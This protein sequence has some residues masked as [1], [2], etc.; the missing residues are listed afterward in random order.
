M[1]VMIRFFITVCLVFAALPVQGQDI[2]PGAP[3]DSPQETKAPEEA[4]PQTSQPQPAGSE[5][6]EEI[7]TLGPGNIT[8]NFKGADIKTVLSY[9][10]EVSG[11]DIVPSQDVKGPVDVKL[12]NKPWKVALDIIVRN[13][14]FAYER[15]GDIIRVDTVDKLRQQEVVTETYSL[16]Y[17]VAKDIT[18][19]IKD[20]LS[21][22]GKIMYDERTN[23]LLVTDIPTN[24]Y[25]ISQVVDRLDSK[26][27]QVLIEAKIIETVLG[28][29]EKMGIDW[30]IKMAASGAKRP[31]TLPFEN[32]KAPFGSKKDAMK[33]FFPMVQI[34]NPQTATGVGSISTTT[35]ASEFPSD[36]GGPVGFPFAEKDIFTF[37]T[38]D[39]SQFSAVLEMLK[40][41]ADTQVVSNPRVATLN[42][43]EAYIMV[44]ETLGMP[45]YE[46]NT[47]TGKMEITGY[48][49]KDLGIKMKVT[50]HIN[51]REEIVVDLQPE[52]SDLLRYDTLDAA[53]GVKAPVFSTRVAT[54]QVMVKDGE[55]IFIGG[56]IKERDRD[57]KKKMP[58]IGDLLGDV[59]YIGLLF[60]KKE[61]IKEKT[62]LIFF[63][64]VY[65]ANRAKTF[66]DIKGLP[67]VSKAYIPVFSLY[68]ER[69]AAE[70]EAKK[71]KK[72]AAK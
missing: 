60:S 50:P 5:L 9:I 72:K 20:M 28:S 24:I 34:Q 13:Y 42:N 7:Q 30:N 52:I 65:L 25:K 53:S 17:A 69:G 4:P 63:I 67:N 57:Y 55:T 23:M 31:T 54:T 14:G 40:E 37:G 21:D 29:N 59:P 36:A 45:T 33:E 19:S 38:L 44:G 12:T 41:R 62:E 26:T 46:R 6:K 58:L 1:R 70:A 27:P 47:T 56:L 32:F 8:V 66:D 10:S 2:P 11:V 35:V 43:K 18:N 71:K 3:Q 49:S 48:E 64:T 51:K 68:E 61:K 22:R 16:N 39:F 15:E